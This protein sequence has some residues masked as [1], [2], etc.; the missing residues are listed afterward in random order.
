MG[1]KVLA[2]ILTLIIICTSISGVCTASEV[3]IKSIDPSPYYDSRPNIWGNYIVWRRAINQNGNGVIEL[4]EPSWIMVHNIKNGKSWSITPVNKVISGNIYEHAESPDIW[5]GKIIYEAQ[6]DTNSYNT[7][8][9]MHNISGNDTWQIPI[10]STDYAHGH[11]HA[12]YGEWIVYTHIADGNRQAYLYN[13]KDG[14]YRTIIGR[15][16]SN[17]TY[18]LAMNDKYVA[19]TVRDKNRNYNIWVYDITSTGIERLNY[20]SNYSMMIATSIY[21]GEIG[22]SILEEV[23]NSTQWNVYRYNL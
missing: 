1:S 10:R 21:G 11:L 2:I 18:G 12:I 17:T 15:S 16:E 5:N 13:Y 8:L 7:H 4:S 3:T 9:F 20:S 14:I 22:L 23:G 6:V 19:L